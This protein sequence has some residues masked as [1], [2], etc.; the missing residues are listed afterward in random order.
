MRLSRVWFVSAALCVAVFGFAVGPVQA[1]DPAG[2]PNREFM[3]GR[4]TDR[5]NCST[6]TRFGADGKFEG[7]L[8]GSGIWT[9]ID[10]RLFLNFADGRRISMTVR[11]IDSNTLQVTQDNGNR[12]TSV[13]CGAGTDA[14]PG[15]GPS[16]GLPTLEQFTAATNYLKEVLTNRP[17][18]FIRTDA[19]T[20]SDEWIDY[21]PTSVNTRDCVTI[22]EV[23]EVRY[24]S[25]STGLK[26][27][28]LDGGYYAIEER[29]GWPT[30]PFEIDW[31]TAL[32]RRAPALK[33][34]EPG[35]RWASDAVLVQNADGEVFTIGSWPVDNSAR[36]MRRAIA[37]IGKTCGARV[38]LPS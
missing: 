3:F 21:R 8:A 24:F 1:R 35:G 14:A 29:N 7:Q 19:N 38:E 17:D 10:G 31:R 27:A 13:R 4:W 22:I 36:K 6:A 15:G 18:W 34:A 16:D 20:P 26:T 32:I 37:L 30:P 25:P 11:I 23:E 28:P 2:A 9:L 5:H 33:A 12:T